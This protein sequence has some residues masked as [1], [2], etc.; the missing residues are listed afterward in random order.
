MPCPSSA[1]AGTNR[2]GLAAASVQGC[3]HFVT[4]RF[5]VMSLL[6]NERLFRR[7]EAVAIGLYAGI[8]AKERDHAAV[9]VSEKGCQRAG[10]ASVGRIRGTGDDP[11]WALVTAVR[12]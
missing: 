8:S 10:P 9:V 12:L 1:K 7:L 6:T 2:A 11:R 3:H 5:T 4:F